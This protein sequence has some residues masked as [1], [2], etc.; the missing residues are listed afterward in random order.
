[1]SDYDGLEYCPNCEEETIF[2]FSGSGKKAL[3][4]QC[5]KTFFIKN[6]VI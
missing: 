4:N 6:E 2:T 1:M 5:L 3:C